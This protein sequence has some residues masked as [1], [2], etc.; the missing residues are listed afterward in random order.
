MTMNDTEQMTAKKNNRQQQCQKIDDQ[1]GLFINNAADD[2]GVSQLWCH[3]LIDDLI[4]LRVN[5]DIYH[6]SQGKYTAL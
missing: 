6:H 2:E 5:I 3:I 4:I 1:Q